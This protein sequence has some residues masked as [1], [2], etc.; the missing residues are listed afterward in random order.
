[1]LFLSEEK[2]RIHWGSGLHTHVSNPFTLNSLQ[3]ERILLRVLIFPLYL[4]WRV[5][6]FIRIEGERVQYNEGFIG[7]KKG[8]RKPWAL[9]CQELTKA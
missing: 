2:V 3:G 8:K 1:M 6:A 5:V 4:A 7:E 9:Q